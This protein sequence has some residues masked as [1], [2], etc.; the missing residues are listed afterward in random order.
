[1]K[2]LFLTSQVQ[3]VA[4]SIAKKL[5]NLT[6]SKAVFI[7]TAIHARA[8]TDAELS[9]HYANKAKLAEAGFNFDIYDIKGKSQTDLERDLANYS[10]MYV[11]GGDPFYFQKAAEENNFGEY[12]AKR[13]AQGLIYLGTS[14]GSIVVGP[15]TAS[16]SRP[17]KT[18]DKQGLSSTKGLGIVNFVVMPHWGDPEK[19]STYFAHKLPTSY[20]EDYPYIMLSD[21]QYIEVTGD[22]F[23]LVDVSKA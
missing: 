8:H 11:E 21:H 3:H 12:L 5:G 23:Q 15:D 20:Q 7:D 10:I 16:V 4:S 17:G 2:H 22:S 18:P 6:A 9:W 14:A 13:L 19:S 1:M